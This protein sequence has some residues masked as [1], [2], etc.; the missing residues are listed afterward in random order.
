M[1]SI[2]STIGN[3]LIPVIIFHLLNV[4][5]FSLTKSEKIDSLMQEYYKRD[6][7][8]G[9]IL[10]T[11]YRK[12]VY[13]KS[14][15]YSNIETKEELND[16]TIFN[17]A[18][19]TKQFTATAIMILFDRDELFYDDELVKYIP[20]LKPI[21]NRITIRHLL[22]HTSGLPEYLEENICFA[23]ISNQDVI[24]FVKNSEKLHFKPGEQYSYCNTGY[25]MLAVI[26]E[27]ISNQTYHKFLEENIFKPLL[28]KNTFV[29]AINKREIKN[30]AIGY[31]ED[32][33]I[34]KYEIF[35]YG[36]G[37]IYSTIQD[38]FKWEQSLYTEKLVKATTLME[39][40][41]KSE[42]NNGNKADYGYGWN[43]CESNQVVYHRG[44]W[45]GAN[46]SITRYI[47]DQDA[48]IIL[49]NFTPTNDN[50][51]FIIE[52]AIE[53]ILANRPI[54]SPQFGR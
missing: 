22:N 48:I 37:N 11:E 19:L 35:T 7:F 24:N 34:D 14:F 10:V 29:Y 23:G 25:V 32:K 16:S 54:S 45:A 42:L 9:S 50:N 51:M 13:K 21:A 17:L 31:K 41:K 38:M 2:S 15:G 49:S 46:T 52:S 27:R 26:V 4:K 1:I 3:I 30:L 40:F 6:L 28:M 44:G 39:A 8:N 33:T 18:S 5:C 36:D 20:E 12:I 47:D 43:I 53:D